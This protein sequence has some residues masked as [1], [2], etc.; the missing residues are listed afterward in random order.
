[1]GAV[2]GLAEDSR[3]RWPGRR[4][5]VL[6]TVVATASVRVVA[7]GRPIVVVVPSPADHIVVALCL[8]SIAEAVVHRGGLVGFRCPSRLGI[9]R[10]LSILSRQRRETF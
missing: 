10:G 5:V 4:T 2:D 9:D 6:P 3:A 1:M 8:A 7:S